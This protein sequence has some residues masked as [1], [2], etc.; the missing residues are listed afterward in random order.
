MV[1]L[2]KVVVLSWKVPIITCL[3]FSVLGGIAFCKDFYINN[4]T[5]TSINYYDQ[6]KSSLEWMYND[7]LKSILLPY[8]QEA[9]SNYY[10]ENTRY[11]PIVDLYGNYD[12]ISFESPSAY[13]FIIKFE[14]S[15]F[16]GA[17]NSIGVDHIT[18]RVSYGEVKLEKFEHVKSKPI[19]P[20]LQAQD[21][22]I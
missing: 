9:V 4:D 5:K 20:W 21:Q 17:H 6:P 13:V 19:P 3:I 2:K 1:Y 22:H 14:V 15:P 7:A 18:L 16:L 11:S 8:V 10:E 12:I